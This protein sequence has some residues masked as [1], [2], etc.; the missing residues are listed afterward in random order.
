MCAYEFTRMVSKWI[1]L[2]YSKD[3]RI[4]QEIQDSSLLSR[5]TY[6]IKDQQNGDRVLALL[7]TNYIHLS[8]S[9]SRCAYLIKYLMYLKIPY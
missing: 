8:C 4:T 3:A 1:P 7:Y 5:N 9:V 6:G 2:V